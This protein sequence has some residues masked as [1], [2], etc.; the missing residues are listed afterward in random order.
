MSESGSQR[1]LFRQWRDSLNNSETMIDEIVRWQMTGVLLK[2]TPVVRKIPFPKCPN[3]S[4][5][6]HGLPTQVCHGSFD[7]PGNE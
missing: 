4:N 3:C 6:W 2:R 1:D 7:T 5:E